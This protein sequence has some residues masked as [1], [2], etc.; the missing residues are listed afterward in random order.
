MAIDDKMMPSTYSYSPVLHSAFI[1]T[2][3]AVIGGYPTGVNRIARGFLHRRF[4]RMVTQYA[5]DGE[6]D[7]SEAEAAAVQSAV[8]LATTRV[9][10]YLTVRENG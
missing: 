3:D 9:D 1:D 2:N 5:V 6:I 10:M 7:R 8:R 4:A